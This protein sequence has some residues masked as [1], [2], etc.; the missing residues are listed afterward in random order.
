MNELTKIR[1]SD[2]LNDSD[3]QNKINQNEEY[4]KFQKQK[5]EHALA[6]V[7]DDMK[8]LDVNTL[9][10][11]SSSKN[12]S[13][14]FNNEQSEHGFA[15]QQIGP[16]YKARVLEISSKREDEDEEEYVEPPDD[17]ELK[18]FCED[19]SNEIILTSSTST[20][21]S[22]IPQVNV[23]NNNNNKTNNTVNDM[24]IKSNNNGV[25]SS[26]MQINKFKGNKEVLNKSIEEIKNLMQIDNTPNRNGSYFLNN[27]LKKINEL[28]T[29]PTN[30]SFSNR[31]QQS[32]SLNSKR[33]LSNKIIE[34][35][36]KSPIVSTT[37]VDSMP[38]KSFNLNV[39]CGNVSS[40][41][42][43]AASPIMSQTLPKNSSIFNN[44]NKLTSS[45]P[46]RNSISES[47]QQINTTLSADKNLK[48]NNTA[49]VDKQK[50]V[51]PPIMRKPENAEEIIRKLTGA[52]GLKTSPDGNLTIRLS[53]SRATDV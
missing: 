18:N 52:N 38:N 34:N 3:Q 16:P 41:T 50:S 36:S 51:P 7:L 31:V 40:T 35:Q 12:S 19:D 45:T 53:K 17:D 27:S 23:N 48:I 28:I 20:S 9:S 2:I 10:N 33:L 39:I 43:N 37:T 4:L 8:Q 32:P 42:S 30:H 46:I 24:I 26:P 21:T 14:S 1:E 5:I 25:A 47:S 13:L 6:S 44:H 49:Q 29:T 11:K 15:K 22:T